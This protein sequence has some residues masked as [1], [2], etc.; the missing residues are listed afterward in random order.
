[1]SNS[2]KFLEVFKGFA[3]QE[4][5]LS[6][7]KIFLVTVSG[8]IDSVVL[9]KICHLLG[10]N[11]CL[12]H[13]NFQLRAAESDADEFFVQ[14]LAK[15]LGIPFYCKKFDTISYKEKFAIGTQEAARTL[16][17]EY[18]QELA[19]S[20][21][22]DTKK[23]VCI[24]TAHHKDD[25]IETSLMFLFRGSG[26]KGLL[27]IAAKNGIIERPFLF[28]TKDALRQYATDNN[29]LY[30]EDASNATI[31]YTRN[32]IR[33]KIVPTIE[34]QFPEV[35]DMLAKDI[36]LFKDVYKI[37]RIGIEKKIKGLVKLESGNINIPV[38]R[39][40]KMDAGKACLHEI[41]QPLGFSAAQEVEVLKL[42][43]AS[44]GKYVSG[45]KYRVIRNRNWLVIV[46]NTEVIA[47]TIVI[48]E[49]EEFVN[50]ESGNLTLQKTDVLDIITDKH[51]ALLD[52]DSIKFP[53][54]LRKW[55]PG[56]YFYPLGMTKKKKL[57][58]FFIDEKFSLPQKDAT[59]LL[60]SDGK[61][62][63]IVGSRIDNRFKVN[64]K[65]KAAL[66]IQLNLL[67]K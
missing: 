3:D 31:D 23:Q 9:A 40:Q 21:S 55:K 59:W 2:D 37:Y 62:I 6:K 10:Y 42:C 17:Y 51:I 39:L 64:S 29:I 4:K 30:R 41:L 36:E 61:I 63:W 44:T 56:D 18:F 47:S 65:T 8:G 58:R 57:S 66:K 28:A 25:N 15:E 33:N 46:P 12:V 19:L 20:I 43:S 54:I 1:M 48:E 11:I 32:F 27:G 35:K 22:K 38:L 52:F 16:R 24:L 13:C 50:F 49:N 14:A 34:E 67:S 26:I 53:F 7:D 45:K 60:E 5:L